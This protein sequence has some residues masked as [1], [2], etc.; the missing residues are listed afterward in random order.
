M[1]GG[2]LARIAQRREEHGLDQGERAH[3]RR[4][5]ERQLQRQNAAVRIADQME[6]AVTA[7]KQGAE[8]AQLGFELEGHARRPRRGRAVSDQV[9]RDAATMERPQCAGR[10]TPQCA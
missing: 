7:R 1:V 8:R 9:G 6:C 2:P 3:P 5:G 4:V 10:V